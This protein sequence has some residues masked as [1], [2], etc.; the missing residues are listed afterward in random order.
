MYIYI[1]T[2]TYTYIYI[3]T[4]IHIEAGAELD[5]PTKVLAQRGTL[6]IFDFVSDPK[7]EGDIYI[8]IYI[9]I[10]MCVYIYIY[11]Y[12]CTCILLYVYLS[13]SLYIYIYI[14]GA[15]VFCLSSSPKKEEGGVH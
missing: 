12:I 7:M 10:C 6:A 5:S 9:Y 2:Y 1:Y 3:Y 8:Y 4:C 11:I 15:E 14:Y 13:L